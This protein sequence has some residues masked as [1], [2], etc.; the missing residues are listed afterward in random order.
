MCTTKFQSDAPVRSRNSFLYLLVTALLFAVL[1]TFFF[2]NYSVENTS[3]IKIKP[4]IPDNV[5][6]LLVKRLSSEEINEIEVNRQDI[7]YYFN[8]STISKKKVVKRSAEVQEEMASTKGST[9]EEFRLSKTLL[10][11]WYN[12]T[13]KVYVPGFVD[14]AEEKSRT[15]DG[16]L[17]IKFRVVNQ[18]NKIE[19]NSVNLKLP[20]ELTKIALLVDKPARRLQRHTNDVRRTKRQTSEAL[21]DET[22]V[23]QESSGIQVSSIIQNKTLDKTI[24]MLDK[25]LEE[26]KNYYLQFT[27][28]GSFGSLTGLYLTQYVEKSGTQRYAAVTQMEPTY[29]RQMVP[30]FDEP[31]FKAIWSLKIIHPRGSRA[32]GNAKELLED[33]KS[34]V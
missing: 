27:Y 11:I 1:C 29:A 15:F 4:I 20:K 16:A 31:E 13:I 28:S 7:Q 2:I 3:E 18:T 5:D 9:V 12:L 19:L 22:D 21:I 24:F 6:A 25:F 10:P 8:S 23:L 14:I 26:G 34:V 30:C 33:R 32:V 17:I